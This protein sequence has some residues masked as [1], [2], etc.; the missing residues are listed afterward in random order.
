VSQEASL[1]KTFKEEVS[2]AIRS[3]FK[4]ARFN[5]QS[6]LLK[7]IV[8]MKSREKIAGVKISNSQAGSASFDH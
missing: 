2:H 3:V 6:G 5:N 8:W 1:D 4:W 7:Y